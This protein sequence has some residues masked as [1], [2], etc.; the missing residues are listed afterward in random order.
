MKKTL[1]LLLTIFLLCCTSCKKTCNHLK[2]VIEE[3]P[4]TCVSEGY[5][6]SY[7]ETCDVKEK[8]SLPLGYHTWSE[9]EV[10]QPLTY[11]QTEKIKYICIHCQSESI[12]TTSFNEITNK[13]LVLEQFIN[14]NI[15]IENIDYLFKVVDQAL[16]QNY[17]S[18]TFEGNITNEFLKDSYLLSYL[19][20]NNITFN[21]SVNRNENEYVFTFDYELSPTMI[22]HQSKIDKALNLNLQKQT[23][24]RSEDFNDFV[25]EKVEQSLKVETTEQLSSCLMK[26]IKPICK[27]NSNAYQ[28]YEIMKSILRNIIHDDMTDFE[29]ILAIH[30]YLCTYTNYDYALYEQSLNPVY[31]RSGWLEGVF[32]DNLG[33]CGSIANAFTSLCNIEGIICVTVTGVSK[34]NN[35]GHAWNKVYLDGAWYV[36]DLT[37]DIMPLVS[38]TKKEVT[39]YQSFLI[40]ESYYINNYDI[41]VFEDLKCNK[42]YNKYS[43]MKYIYNNRENDFVIDSF[44]ELI[45]VVAYLEYSTSYN[46]SISIL[47]NYEFDNFEEELERAFSIIR[48]SNDALYYT[49]VTNEYVIVN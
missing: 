7:C 33:V 11:T 47:M 9:G 26:G 42:N 12:S 13:D 10:I 6:I 35:V 37:G 25:I 40:D 36:V 21:T 1:L 16:M 5:I 23:K 48:S 15:Y 27:E 34:N 31:Y 3:V 49:S 24:T 4:S 22:S 45:N 38:R 14:E 44:Y 39:L 30:D 28:V 20:P 32:F 43:Q 19:I 2:T 29:K 46:G 18:V 41:Y 17:S 8:T